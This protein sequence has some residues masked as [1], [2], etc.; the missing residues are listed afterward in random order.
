MLD[1]CFLS[2]LANFF[3]A[4]DEEPAAIADLCEACHADRV[5]VVIH[6]IRLVIRVP[7]KDCLLPD[8]DVLQEDSKSMSLQ[9]SL[10]THDQN[11][12]DEYV[13]FRP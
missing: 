10:K 9:I 12:F 7:E 4:L 2:Q 1:M 8:M 3:A 5:L 6:P 13:L 11:L